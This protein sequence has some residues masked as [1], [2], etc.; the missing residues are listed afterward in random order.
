[1]FLREPVNRG[2]I[3]KLQ[4]ETQKEERQSLADEKEIPSDE[5]YQFTDRNEK[6]K[7]NFKS[8]IPLKEQQI[9]IVSFLTGY[10]KSGEVYEGNDKNIFPRAQ[11]VL[12]HRHSLVD[13]DGDLLINILNG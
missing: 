3:K 2:L 6:K 5:L 1:M 7:T 12:S 9:Q 11:L 13:L 10:L 4:L 8:F